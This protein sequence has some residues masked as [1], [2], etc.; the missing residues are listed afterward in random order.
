MDN[1][2]FLNTSFDFTYVIRRD[3]SQRA[4]LLFLPQQQNKKIELDEDESVNQYHIICVAIFVFNVLI[5]IRK[6]L[7]NTM[8]NR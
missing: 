5:S 8:V 2:F 3:D 1:F 4:I 6:M 7:S